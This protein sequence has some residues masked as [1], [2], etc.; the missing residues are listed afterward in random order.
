MEKQPQIKLGS[1]K[2]RWIWVLKIGTWEGHR[3]P[4]SEWCKYFDLMG[5]SFEPGRW[6]WNGMDRADTRTIIA[7]FDV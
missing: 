5:Q 1:L 4:Q 7:G 2:V 6:A 3:I